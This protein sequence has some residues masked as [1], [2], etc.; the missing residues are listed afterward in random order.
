MPQTFNNFHMLHSLSVVLLSQLNSAFYVH[1]TRET[2]DNFS[3]CYPSRCW[4]TLMMLYQHNRWQYSHSPPIAPSLLCQWQTYKKL[5]QETC[6]SFL[7]RNLHQK[8]DAG[9]LYKNLQNENDWRA[10]CHWI[11]FTLN[12]NRTFVQKITFRACNT[13]GLSITSH[14]GCL[15]QKPKS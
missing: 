6:T 8:F 15:F 3:T 9:F 14:L 10:K 12:A 4:I 7:T 11:T 5:I 13:C 1:E 2:S